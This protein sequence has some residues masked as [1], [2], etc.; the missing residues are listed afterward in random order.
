MHQAVHHRVKL[1]T[2]MTLGPPYKSHQENCAWCDVKLSF[3]LIDQSINRSIDQLQ[4]RPL[5][6]S[7]FCLKIAVLI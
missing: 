1:K 7:V 3:L 6:K 5:A 2:P 4:R